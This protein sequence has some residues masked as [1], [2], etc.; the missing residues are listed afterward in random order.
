LTGGMILQ[1]RHHFAPEAA[2]AAASLPDILIT[3]GGAAL[4]C[5][6]ILSTSRLTV[7][8]RLFSAATAS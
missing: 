5:F 3:L 1:Q 7:Y 8:R 4:Q 6:V 2:I